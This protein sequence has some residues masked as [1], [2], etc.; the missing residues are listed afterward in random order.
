MIDRRAW[1]AAAAA[2]AAGPAAPGAALAAAVAVPRATPLALPPLPL[3]ERRL[4]N[5]LHVVSAA[6]AGGG[7]VAVQMWYRVGSKDDPEGRSGFAHL[8]E[9]M[10]F[11]GTRHMPAEMFD[12]LTEDVGGV[13]NA[14]TADDT[15]AY[16]AEVPANH[17]ERLLW[18]EAERLSNLN[19]DAATFASER[20]VVKEEYRQRVEADP[21]GRLFNAIAP[22]GFIRHPYRRPGIGNLAE[23]DAASLDDVRAFHRTFYRPD[24]VTL[25]VVGDFEPAAFDAAVDRYFGRLPKPEG[26]VPRVNVT[27][28]K[29][30]RDER[31]A[32][33]APNV[34][35]PALMLLWQAP[36]ADHPDAAALKV[37][38]A[39]LSAGDSSRLN[40]ALVYRTQAAQS[41]GFEV[42]LNADAGLLIGYAIAA[43]PRPAASL[44][45]PLLA[46]IERLARGPLPAAELDKVRA[47]LLTAALAERQTPAGRA[48]SLGFALVMS[49]DVRE[50]DAELARLQ[51]V[52]AADVKRVLN[53]WVLGARRVTATYTAGKGA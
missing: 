46:E 23:L 32:L 41:A 4:A 30:T 27:E 17:L 44:E 50:A 40:E 36:R 7:T 25:I 38:S 28:P 20:D 39:L 21:Y 33:T 35:L 34:P 11:K 18:A 29:R 19:V 49:G 15:T 9:H 16:L 31:V 45:K 22:L 48:Q 37:A 13:N 6:V 14:F 26:T 52:T 10:M 43:G 1:L 3:R 8:F 2:F 24:N 5:G 12:R 47:R 42:M 53:T 51:A